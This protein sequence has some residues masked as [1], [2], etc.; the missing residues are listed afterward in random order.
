MPK[1]LPPPLGLLAPEDEGPLKI[2]CFAPRSFAGST[3]EL[4]AAG[5]GIAVQSVSA[6]PG[7]H[8]VDFTLDGAS[9]CYRCRYRSYN[10]SAWQASAFSTD[11]VVNGAGGDAAGVAPGAPPTP[12]RCVSPQPRVLPAATPAPPRP[13]A[14]PCPLPPPYGKVP[15]AAP[16]GCSR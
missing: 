15:V 14:I 2:I 9:R 8:K 3:F 6:E 5:A 7:Q 4:F 10:G 11:I 16:G 13:P 1:L 12:T